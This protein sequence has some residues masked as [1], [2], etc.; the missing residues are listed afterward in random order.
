[1]DIIEKIDNELFVSHRVIAERTNNKILSV[2]KLITDNISELEEF[3][4]LR[5]K[6]EA[7]SEEKLKLN[8]DAK[9]EKTYFLNEPQVTLLLTFMRNNEIVK[10]FKIKLVKEFFKMRTQLQISKPVQK[11]NDLISVSTE[12][13]RKEFEALE[14]ALKNSN[15]SESEKQFLINQV[16]QKI[17]F[18]N[19]EKLKEYK[20]V[21]TLTQ[22]LS[23]FQVGILPHNFNWKLRNFGILKFS[24]NSWILLD[25]RFGRNC[26]FENKSNPKYYKSSFQEL[27]D[28]VLGK[29]K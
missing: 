13:M 5:F 29:G 6:I 23:E 16:L 9:A 4:V 22:L 3:G 15:I 12:E 19:L 28:I 14:F 2:Q 27:L 17:N 20:E 8:P 26:P 21:F 10:K 7:V 11:R 25:S 1:M 24:E 18:A